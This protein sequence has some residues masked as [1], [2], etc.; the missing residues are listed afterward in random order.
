VLDGA[1]RDRGVGGQ[2]IRMLYPDGHA[3]TRP[4]ELSVLIS[5]EIANGLFSV[6]DQTGHAREFTWAAL[7]IHGPRGSSNAFRAVAG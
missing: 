7:G 3:V 4:I 5:C 2:L 6:N 1:G